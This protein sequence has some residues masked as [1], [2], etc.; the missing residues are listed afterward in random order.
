MGILVLLHKALKAML[1]SQIFLFCVPKLLT[2]E[3]FLCRSL[4]SAAWSNLGGW[5]GHC[6]KS[7]SFE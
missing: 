7:K 2:V 1:L 6:P 3:V 5:L 4:V